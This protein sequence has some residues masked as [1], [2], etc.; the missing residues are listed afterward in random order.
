MKSTYKQALISDLIILAKADNKITASEYDFIQRLARRMDV[1]AVEVDA[2][3]AHPQPS[4]PIFSE[5]ERI[6]H[7]HKLV[8][9][10]NVDGD[11]DEREIAAVREFGLRMG[12][13]PGAIDQVL[14]RMEDY[15][16]KIIP[17]DQLI[18]IFQSY[19]N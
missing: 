17:S 13:R 5:L 11:T 3:F 14:K 9:V 15:E 12:I 4:Q 8:L 2:L 16:D 7:F 19:Y 18:Q 6:T 1:T 10:M